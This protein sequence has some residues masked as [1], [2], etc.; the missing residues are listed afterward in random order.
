MLA[1]AG[2]LLLVLTIALAARAT[3]AASQL[4]AFASV[5]AGTAGL[6]SITP[7]FFPGGPAFSG[8][9]GIPAD[10]QACGFSADS[11]AADHVQTRGSADASWTASSP[12]FS[13]S[14][15][16]HAEFASL[17]AKASAA[18]QNQ[19]NVL[20]NAAG[21]FGAFS[22]TLTVTSPTHPSGDGGYVVFDFAVDG[23][24]GAHNGDYD[25]GVTRFLGRASATVAVRVGTTPANVL[26]AQVV[27]N[28]PQV[29]STTP[30]HAAGFSAT[31]EP[32]GWTFA[33]STAAHSP[34]LAFE[35]GTPFAF[36]AGLLAEVYPQ[37]ESAAAGDASSNFFATARL[38]GIE[39]LDAG[40]SPVSEFQIS[41]E[42]GTRYVPEPERASRGAV[43][44]AGLL[45]LAGRARRR[46]LPSAPRS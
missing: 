42:S 26:T 39:V 6:C 38:T 11:G 36:A 28:G 25:A 21:A 30:L 5:E 15:Q 37:T 20:G 24:L 46:A 4:E 31:H 18:N 33:G 2:R 35:F 12:Q 44:I 22:D 23:Q 3:R 8:T 10:F 27:L 9:Y 32:T 7:V 1:W 16:A 14:S 13:G 19:G 34:P 43:A 45:A 41:S 40:R 17:G 29:P